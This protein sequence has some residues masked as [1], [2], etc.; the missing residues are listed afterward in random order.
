[1]QLSATAGVTLAA[2]LCLLVGV[3]ARRPSPGVQGSGG[4]EGG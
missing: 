2:L 4:V 1:M 3:P